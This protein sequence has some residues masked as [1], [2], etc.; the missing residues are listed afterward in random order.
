MPA[1]IHKCAVDVPTVSAWFVYSVLRQ[2]HL[3]DSA[4]SI[5]SCVLI[6]SELKITYYSPSL[7]TMALIRQLVQTERTL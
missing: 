2:M 1:C 4:C 5:F 6:F 3:I 7:S